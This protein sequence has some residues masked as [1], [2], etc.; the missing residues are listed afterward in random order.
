VLSRVTFKGNEAVEG[1][2]IY[3]NATYGGRVA[4]TI[5]RATFDGNSAQD[6][7]GAIAIFSF[8]SGTAAPV[9]ASTTFQA[10]VA[11]NMGGAIALNSDD[12]GRST[13]D[14]SDV[15][16]SGNAAQ[17]SILGSGGAIDLGAYNGD[18][19]VRISRTTF[20]DNYSV[21]GG[22]FSCE[23]L[24]GATCTVRASNST[25]VNNAAQTGGA[26]FVLAETYASSDVQLD[27]VTVSANSAV[28]GA[29]WLGAGGAIADMADTGSGKLQIWNSIF[30]N[31]VGSTEDEVSIDNVDATIQSS[32]VTGGCP[33]G[34]TCASTRDKDPLL[35]PLGYHW[36]YTPVMR[37]GLLGSAID[38][39][40]DATCELTDQRNF[41]RPIGAHCD[42][43][44][45]EMRLP[46]DDISYPAGF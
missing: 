23:A 16:F 3:G 30:W 28:G 36:G 12:Y 20:N 40:D 38:A 21:Q 1:A 41:A 11:A 45:V 10:N 26:L 8:Y 44:A 15:V 19:T 14:V 13:L 39:G 24:S 42:I 17:N 34:V 7:G 31:D 5:S 4:P 43:G 29:T 35:E 46:S 2:G 9:I 37:P 18:L 6:G 32:V 22:A 33:T 27:N 25:F